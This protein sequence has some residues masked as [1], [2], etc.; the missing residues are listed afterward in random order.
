MKTRLFH[1]LVLLCLA[2]P[3]WAAKPCADMVA[4]R[5][6]QAKWE[7]T[8]LTRAVFEQWLKK[9]PPSATS[10]RMTRAARLELLRLTSLGAD[11]AEWEIAAAINAGLKQRTPHDRLEPHSPTSGEE[12]LTRVGIGVEYSL[13]DGAITLQKIWEGSPA[14]AHGLR[15]GDQIEQ[16]DQWSVT[17]DDAR[18]V[19]FR[20]SSAQM[21]RNNT[22]HLTIRRNGR[23]LQFS[24]RPASITAPASV[25]TK[26]ERF[27]RYLVGMMA[28]SDFS[29]EYAEQGVAK[30]LDS[31]H[32]QKIQ[33][34]ILDLRG[35]LGG[36]LDVVTKIA[37]YFLGKKRLLVD[38]EP[39][40]AEFRHFAH[41]THSR[42]R[43]QAPMMVLVDSSSASA[44]EVLAG[45]LQH[46][47]LAYLVGTPSYGKGT[48]QSSESPEALAFN[49]LP[50]RIYTTRSLYFLPNGTTPQLTGLVPDFEVHQPF[51]T[52]SF[53]REH[54]L[55]FA[56][57]PPA[58]WH[59]GLDTDPLRDWLRASRLNSTIALPD[60]DF[61][62]ET[63]LQLLMEWMA[64]R[65]ETP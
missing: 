23:R 3:A 36:R 30:G 64:L 7:G 47:G 55:P 43:I 15:M 4:S 46:Y 12:R 13:I 56:V 19:L 44:A 51:P 20:L 52:P 10:D 21:R 53:L 48:V 54:E 45:A 5:H 22:V 28:L 11:P 25:E 2:L 8:G 24:I 34:M 40:T 26:V 41:V 16:V 50:V 27:G 6:F 49:G 9:L 38:E 31:F 60:G 1:C 32:R 35:N 17:Q 18:R 39:L 57:K 37:G 33:G 14:S 29:S 59:P 63:A 58:T 61:Q 65:G 62:K 42:E